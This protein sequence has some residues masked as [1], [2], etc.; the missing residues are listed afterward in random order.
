ML[1]M[2]YLLELVQERQLQKLGKLLYPVITPVQ[3]ITVEHHIQFLH[4]LT[5]LLVYI[6]VLLV[7]LVQILMYALVLKP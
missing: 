2:G 3:T 1:T 6:T 5:L 4:A 7:L